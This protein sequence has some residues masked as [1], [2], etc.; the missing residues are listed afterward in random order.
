MTIIEDSTLV[1][2][3]DTG[4]N[5]DTS[6]S[7]E[8]NET[9][10]G[11]SLAGAALVEAALGDPV[12]SELLRRQYQSEK[13]KGVAKVQKDVDRVETQLEKILNRLSPEDQQVLKGVQQQ[14]MIDELYQERYSPRVSGTEQ[15]AETQSTASSLDL[16]AAFKDA[17]YD[18]GKLTTED[19]EFAD[20]Y[21]SQTEL[22]NALLKRNTSS[23][24]PASIVQGSGGSTPHQAEKLSM[25][26]AQAKL[27]DLR[28]QYPASKRPKEVQKEMD[29][30]DNR[31]AEGLK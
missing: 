25:E 21:T 1:D 4:G 14:V 28:L 16:I 17:G 10:A 15:K 3:E 24:D 12:A 22:K 6:Q 2:S 23:A 5:Q 19:I 30:L 11:N 29:D 13:D 8:S 27:E 9:Q 26:V 20:K 31:L 18:L 7:T